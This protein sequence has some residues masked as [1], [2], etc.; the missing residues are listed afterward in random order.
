MSGSIVVGVDGSD[1]ARLAVRWATRG[2]EM[3]DADVFLL[4]AWDMPGDADNPALEM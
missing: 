1:C 4:S 2:A 3:R